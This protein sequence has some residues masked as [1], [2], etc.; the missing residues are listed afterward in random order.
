MIFSDI[1]YSDVDWPTDTISYRH[2]QAIIS[3]QSCWITKRHS[4]GVISTH[5]ICFASREIN[6]SLC[7]TIFRSMLS[8]I[9]SRRRYFFILRLFTIAADNQAHFILS[10][11]KAVSAIL[12]DY[13]HWASYIRNYARNGVASSDELSCSS[14]SQI[15]SSSHS[16]LKANAGC[17]RNNAYEY[18]LYFIQNRIVAVTNLSNYVS[19]EETSEAG[20]KLKLKWNESTGWSYR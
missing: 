16:S 14:Y 6:S 9:W 5:E 2:S 13:I 18:R 15:C 8:S 10:L 19:G 20:T 4:K 3:W 1:I 7:M 17:S 11:I 12:A